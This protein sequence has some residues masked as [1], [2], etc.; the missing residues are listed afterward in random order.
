[1]NRPGKALEQEF[2]N[3]GDSAWG[4]L[5]RALLF[6]MVLP[7]LAWVLL[8]RGIHAGDPGAH[9]FDA[10]R[11][12]HALGAGAGEWWHEMMA[13][14][15]KP[16]MAM[17]LAHLGAPLGKWLGH[18]DSGLLLPTV[19]AGYLALWLLYK[20]LMVFFQDRAAALAG[21]LAVASAPLFLAYATGLWM[22]PLQLLAACWFFWIMAAAPGL[23]RLAGLLHLTAAAAFSLLVMV[24]TPLFCL[25]PGAIAAFRVARA[26]WPK[27]GAWKKSLPLVA[28]AALL[29]F[30]L[31]AWYLG[32]WNTVV[33]H[34]SW[35]ARF[36]YNAMA[37]GFPAKLLFWLKTLAGGFFLLPVL[38][39][40]LAGL[41]VAL[42]ARLASR[43]GNGGDLP[44]AAA[45]LQ[46]VVALWLLSLADNHE[47]RY[48]LPL[49]ACAAVLVA[50]ALWRLK[51]RWLT[52]AALLILG[53]QFAV[54]QL[55]EFGVVALERNPP[56][57]QPLRRESGRLAVLMDEVL[58][59]TASAGG[60]KVMLATLGLWHCGLQ[61][62]ALDIQFHDSKK[63][64]YEPRKARVFESV[65]FHLDKT[66]ADVEKA[67][68][69]ALAPGIGWAVLIH[70]GNC[71]PKIA[72]EGGYRVILDAT[73][74]FSRRV[75]ESGE[76]VRVHLADFP[77]IEIYKRASEE[78]GFGRTMGETSEIAE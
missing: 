57:F 15:P 50:W 56:N 29:V 67:W 31:L 42:G 13:V 69:Y 36:G 44:A 77:E 2:E 9:A 18:F 30:L 74:E 68:E 24:S 61:F 12:Y 26:R 75:R 70:T 73:R 76:F 23:D 43:R 25:V 11:L 34:A 41:T 14:A 38:F 22:Q 64:G 28:L 51:R 55:A 16:P 5:D 62:A 72:T 52:W 46:A 65:E 27:N 6:L 45:V 4:R 10:M 63:P 54:V 48:V 60:G 35:A 49:L 20:S 58:D 40:V 53:A 78:K 33:G 66:G 59:A 47:G 39:A 8:D 19:V 37:F 3:G 7:N 71:P 32:N 21:C 17:W 1:M